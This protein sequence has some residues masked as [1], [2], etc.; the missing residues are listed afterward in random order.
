MFKIHWIILAVTLSSSSI[1]LGLSEALTTGE[2]LNVRTSPEGDSVD[3]LD[4]NTTVRVVKEDGSWSQI[5]YTDNESGTTAYGWVSSQFLELQFVAD[6]VDCTEN[7]AGQQEQCLSTMEPEIQCNKS[8]LDGGYS[9]CTIKIRYEVTGLSVGITPK[10]IHCANTLSSRENLETD[11]A[12]HSAFYEAALQKSADSMLRDFLSM[13][14]E[15][16]RG[17]VVRDFRVENTRCELR[18]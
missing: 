4:L 2:N 5:V 14:I 12:T 1:C 10:K 13:T 3:Q 6:H 9:S 7:T 15:F 17:L 11:W 8:D 16:N 18:F